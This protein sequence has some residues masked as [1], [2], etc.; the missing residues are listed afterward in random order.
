M[1]RDIPAHIPIDVPPRASADHR[2]GQA[3]QVGGPSTGPDGRTRAGATPDVGPTTVIGEIIAQS[4]DLK[5]ADVQ[6]ILEHQRNHSMRFG[7]AAVALGLASE[8]D[9]VSA[10]SQ[11]YQYPYSREGAIGA[12]D[13]LVVASKPFSPQAEAFRGIRAQ[14]IMRVYDD[15]PERR[16]IAVMSPDSGDG[17][18]Y[19][20]ANIAA[21][22]SQLGGRTLLIDANMRSPRLHSVFGIDNSAGLSTILSGR[23]EAQAIHAVPYLPS[24]FVLPVGAIPPNPMELVER[25]RMRLLLAEVLQKFDHVIVDTPA[26]RH[27][28]DGPVIAARCGAALIVARQQKS[29]VAAIQDLMATMAEGPA[30]IAGVILNEF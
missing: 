28:M 5:P 23:T 11:Q 30:Q 24:L 13:E 27:G 17:K 4:R 18:S 25:P 15:Q 16:A 3:A 10:L 12:S 21:A 20:A 7:E 29:H 2:A 6:S 22:F 26:F 14:L 8:D 9:V 19:F 1:N